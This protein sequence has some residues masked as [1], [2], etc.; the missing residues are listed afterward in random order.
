MRQVGVLAAPGLVAL[1]SMIERLAEDHANAQR[2]AE[3]LRGIPGIELK[4]PKPQTNMVYFRLA[5]SSNVTPAEL[6]EQMR[7]RGILADLRLVTH[8]WINSE[9]VANVLTAFREIMIS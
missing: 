5:E 6:I 2:L 7:K 8:R 4:T 9:D 1:K 3:G